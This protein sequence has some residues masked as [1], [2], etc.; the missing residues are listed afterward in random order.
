[1]NDKDFAEIMIILS[2]SYPNFKFTK[3]TVRVYKSMLNDIPLDY[4]QAGA[5]K[6]ATENKWFP[7]VAELREAAFDVML[8]TPEIPSAFEAW[9]EAI[10]HCRRGD[11]TNYSHPLIEKAVKQIGIPYW[12]SMLEEQEMATRAQFFKIYESLFTRATDEIKR[13]P[14]VTA[15]MNENHKSITDGIKSLAKRLSGPTQEAG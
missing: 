5:L 3:D 7:S 6:Y 15:K 2:N 14:A 4:L 10:D 1:M 13:L 11:Y 9:E 8:N 12:Q